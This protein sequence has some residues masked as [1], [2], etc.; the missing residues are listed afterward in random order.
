[1]GLGPPNRYRTIWSKLKNTRSYHGLYTTKTLAPFITPIKKV[2]DS[3]LKDQNLRA[4]GRS[5]SPN[6]I[7]LRRKV[8]T[9]HFA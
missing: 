4:K 7:G 9:S 8:T 3:S 2:V 6:P 5:G 1:M